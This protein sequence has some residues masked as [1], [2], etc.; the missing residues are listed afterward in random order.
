MEVRRVIQV[1]ATVVAFFGE[2][3]VDEAFFGEAFFGEDAGEVINDVVTDV[4]T[5]AVGEDFGVDIYVVLSDFGQICKGSGD[6]IKEK[7][8]EIEEIFSFSL[9]SAQ[10]ITII[11]R[12]HHLS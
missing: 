1:V 3:F 6:F 2:V 12:K 11:Y 7:E 4:V 8:E 10:P 5:D 9:D